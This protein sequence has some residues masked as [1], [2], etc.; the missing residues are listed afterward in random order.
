VTWIH[1]SAT[2]LDDADYDEDQQ[3]QHDDAH[4]DDKPASRRVALSHL[5]Y[6]IGIVIIIRVGGVA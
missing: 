5:V 3:Q 4:Q 1:L 2:A 6:S